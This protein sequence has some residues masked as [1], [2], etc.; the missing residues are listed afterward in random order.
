[1]GAHSDSTDIRICFVGDSL[2]NGAGDPECLGWTGRICAGAR[3]DGYDVTYYN[4][5]VR[6]QT[7]AD[8]ASRWHEETAGSAGRRTWPT[9]SCSWPRSRRA[10]SPGS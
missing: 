2:V 6:G 7:S 9:R 1:M 3:G 8:I 4:L 5:G 10:G